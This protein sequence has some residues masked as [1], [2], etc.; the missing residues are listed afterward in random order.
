MLLGAAWALAAA[1]TLTSDDYA[2][3]LVTMAALDTPPAAEPDAGGCPDGA[4]CCSE[5]SCPAGE[6]CV[7]GSCQEPPPPPV[8]PDAGTP[9][10]CSG[11]DCPDNM[12]VPL[13]PSC[14]DGLQNGDETGSDCGGSCTTAC[15]VGAGC[16]SDADC[17]AGS[18]C[19]TQSSLCVE[20]SCSD[21]SLNGSETSTDC[22]GSCPGCPDGE[23]CNAGSD[24]QSRVCGDDGTC[25]EPSC[26]DDQPN[27]NETGSDCGGPCPQ[28]CGTGEGCEANNDCQS[29]VCR[30]QGCPQGVERCCQAPSCNDDVRNGS[31]S[32]VDCGNQACG[33]C[34]L[35]DSCTINIQCNTGLCQNG[36]CTNPPS[37]T[38]DIL[39]G[40]ESDV[41]CGGSCAPCPDLS[42]CNQAADCANNNCDASGTCISC[43]DNVRNG[44]ETGV[45]CGGADTACR[46]CNAGEV[47]LSNTD[48]VNQFCL[49]GFCT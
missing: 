11:A 4:E 24:C 3:P 44:T 19:S 34:A 1:C 25:A 30:A 7:D 27:G 49:G 45:D 28:N 40:T 8:E 32:D 31:E 35:G 6:S 15:G 39:N 13:E 43:G 42:E 33:Q 36:V 26:N 12:P 21:S 41:D 16:V 10:A 2:P 38:D 46:R 9:P 22:G 5:L 23:A 20:V 18:F 29:G 17:A 14:D 48:C 37:C 47:C